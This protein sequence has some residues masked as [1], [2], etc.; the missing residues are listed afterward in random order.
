MT[1][2]GAAIL[3]LAMVLGTLGIPVPLPILALAAGAFAHRGLI[4]WELALFLA[5]AGATL[6][7]S[8]GYVVGHFASDWA[9]RRYG[10]S[11]VW[12]KAQNRFH[13]NGELAIF[14]TRFLLTPLAV[15]TNLIAGISSYPYPR[16][17]AHTVAGTLVFLLLFG[18]IGFAFSTQWQAAGELVSSYFGWVVAAAIVASVV[19]LLLA[20]RL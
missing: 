5:L 12:H 19:Y 10:E 3:S 6:G 20:P 9:Q 15:P 13:R 11:Q 2:Y 1:R 16:F 8:L 14:L 7:D 4:N 18:G 17:L